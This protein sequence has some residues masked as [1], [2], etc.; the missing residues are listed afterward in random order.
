M[1]AVIT[2]PDAGIFAQLSDVTMFEPVHVL[3]AL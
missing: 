3:L 2:G 1:S